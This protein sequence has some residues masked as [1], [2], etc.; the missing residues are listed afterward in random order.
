MESVRKWAVTVHERATRLK[1]AGRTAGTRYPERLDV[2]I[3]ARRSTRAGEYGDYLSGIIA[4]GRHSINEKC[5]L[6]DPDA[7]AGFFDRPVGGFFGIRTS[8]AC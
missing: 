5:A 1:D 3:I 7:A 4:V 2:A 8:A 6:F